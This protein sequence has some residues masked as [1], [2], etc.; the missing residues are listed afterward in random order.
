MKKWI[1]AVLL[2]LCMVCAAAAVAEVSGDYEYAVL[3]DGTAQIIAYRGHAERLTIPETLDG[4]VVSSIGDAAFSDFYSLMSVSIPDS[5]T[6]LGA[7]PFAN[8]E[9]LEKIIVSPE[10][11]ALEVIDGVLFS[12][13]DKRLVW[14]PVTKTDASYEI[15]N[16]IRV[17]G[18]NAFNLCTSLTSVSIPDSVTTIGKWTFALCKTL[19]SVNI[20]DSVT[21]IGERAFYA[22]RSLTSVTIPD[23]V[24]TIGDYAFAYCESLTSESIPDSVTAIGEDVFAGCDNLTVTVNRN[25]YAAQYCKDNNLTYTYPDALDW[26]NN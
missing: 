20:P 21:T 8:C 19:T 7:N 14:Y 25:S 3:E 16:G 22:C 9:K 24:T 17:I 4:Y 5:V 18:E 23:S 11:P 13:A 12:K 1:A 15:P 26:L 6:T 10:H 2:V